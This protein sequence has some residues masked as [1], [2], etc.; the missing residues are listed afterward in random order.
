MIL[1]LI[2]NIYGSTANREP[3]TANREPRTANQ[4]SLNFFNFSKDKLLFLKICLAL[5]LQKFNINLVKSFLISFICFAKIISLIKNSLSLR[6]VSRSNPFY[7]DCHDFLRSL[8]MT[9]KNNFANLNLVKTFLTSI[10][11]DSLSE[12]IKNLRL[13]IK[14][15]KTR[16]IF[17]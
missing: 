10:T 17:K 3:R 1:N 16:R 6:G 14:K 15:F 11:F 8:A 4:I 5:L 2:N 7:L 13:V 9:I 12:K